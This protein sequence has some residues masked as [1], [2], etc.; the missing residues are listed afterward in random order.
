VLSKIDEK[1]INRRYHGNFSDGEIMLCHPESDVSLYAVGTYYRN[2]RGPLK[3]VVLKE[4][5]KGNVDN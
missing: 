4:Y 3:P 5:R 2:S 1:Q